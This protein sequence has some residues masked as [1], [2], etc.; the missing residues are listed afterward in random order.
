MLHGNNVTEPHGPPPHEFKVAVL[1][2]LNWFVDA[3]LKATHT[4]HHR[5]YKE[6]AK[7]AKLRFEV[8]GHDC[9]ATDE[10]LEQ[11]EPT[12]STDSGD[13]D[14]QHSSSV[15]GIRKAEVIAMAAKVF[16]FQP[17]AQV[18][19]EWAMRVLDVALTVLSQTMLHCRSGPRSRAYLDHQRLPVL[20]A[21]SN[22]GR[23]H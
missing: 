8:G 12:I 7:P 15:S 18:W 17:D 5:V 2:E 13:F 16:G 19:S 3:L 23:G 11:L 22:A 9:L 21:S 4:A 1:N 20:L 6:G 14:D 10:D